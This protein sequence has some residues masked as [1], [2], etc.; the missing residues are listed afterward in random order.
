MPL[1]I[2]N[3]LLKKFG[4]ALGPNAVKDFCTL[5][6]GMVGDTSRVSLNVASAPQTATDRSLGHARLA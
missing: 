4:R 1:F 2:V 3:G 6:T 5:K